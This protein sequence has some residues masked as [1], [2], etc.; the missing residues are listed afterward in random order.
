MKILDFLSQERIIPNM[1]SRDKKGVIDE[2]A[3][4]VA[5]TTSADNAEVAKVLLEREQLGSTG[6]GDGIAI[7]HGRLSS[8]DSIIMGFG[9]SEQGIEYDAID[10]NPV[11]IFFLLLTPENS[12]G[13]HLKV[14]AQISKLLKNKQ[15][16]INLS[17]AKSTQEVLEI[18]QESDENF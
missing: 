16:K 17:N 7:P 2:L 6:I 11:N 18:I 1:Q 10:S 13:G 14:L 12:T 15:F 8:I 3:Q 9:S 4:A 5:D